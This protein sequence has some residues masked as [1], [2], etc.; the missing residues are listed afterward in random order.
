[1][2]GIQQLRPVLWRYGLSDLM[3]AFPFLFPLGFC[4]SW[5]NFCWTLWLICDVIHFK[6]RIWSF[7]KSGST[8]EK[9]LNGCPYCPELSFCW[10][11]HPSQWLNTRALKPSILGSNS[12]WIWASCESSLGLFGPGH[13]SEHSPLS[14]ECWGWRVSIRCTQSSA[15][16]Q[17]STGAELFSPEVILPPLSEMSP[18]HSLLSCPA[19]LDVMALIFIWGYFMPYSFVFWMFVSSTRT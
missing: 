18:H 19:V 2:G 5:S 3:F 13:G 10:Y 6:G 8:H 4:N 12:L 1:M 15:R 14:R 17:V 11:S 16:R 7:L 9:Y